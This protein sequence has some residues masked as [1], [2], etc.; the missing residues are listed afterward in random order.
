MLLQL[1]L[2]YAEAMKLQPGLHGFILSI[3]KVESFM[4]CLWIGGRY[5]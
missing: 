2:Y 3:F 5:E 1:E 4:S